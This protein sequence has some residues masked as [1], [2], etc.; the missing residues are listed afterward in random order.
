MA[1]ARQLGS[2]FPKNNETTGHNGKKK[3]IVVKRSGMCILMVLAM[4]VVLLLNHTIDEIKLVRESEELSIKETNFNHIVDALYGYKGDAYEQAK[5]ISTNVET[6]IKESDM[7]VIKADLDKGI[8]SEDLY[9]IIRQNI[10]GKSL[11]GINNFRNDVIVMTQ[12]GVYEDLSL[13]R[14]SDAN[15]RDWDYE[16]SNSYNQPLEQIAIDKILSHSDELIIAEPTNLLPSSTE[17]MVLDEATIITLKEVYMEEGLEGLR[18]YEVLVPVYITDTGDIFGQQD[19]IQGV[20][21][22]N[23]KI[24]IVQEFNLYDQLS[25]NSKE[26]YS[27]LVESEETGDLDIR[28][29]RIFS[30][31]YLIGIFYAADIV[32]MLFY[33]SSKFN[34]TVIEDRRSSDRGKEN[35]I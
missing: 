17:H 3:F 5:A 35:N 10:E 22:T 9:D 4:S 25:R 12:S 8:F 33:F 2:K 32:C 19:V 18:N 28:Y 13:K 11:N 30:L 34:A 23:H 29:S 26:L 21:Q 27:D 31:L 20:K 15:L 7:D 1:S 16:I 24:I 6:E 14:A